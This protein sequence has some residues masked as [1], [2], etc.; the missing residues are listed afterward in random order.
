MLPL[1]AV[2]DSGKGAVP[3]CYFVVSDSFQCILM[4]GSGSVHVSSGTTTSS[5]AEESASNFKSPPSPLC[6]YMAYIYF[7]ENKDC[8]VGDAA[9][10]T[11]P[12]A[13]R[14]VNGIYSVYFLHAAHV[15][16]QRCQHTAHVLLHSAL[17]FRRSMR[18]TGTAL[19]ERDIKLS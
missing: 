3:G 6:T 10:K 16:P 17:V 5:F 13:L 7:S 11:D 1:K 19:P 8:T 14:G 18:H 12:T 9:A 15:N 4:S 2:R